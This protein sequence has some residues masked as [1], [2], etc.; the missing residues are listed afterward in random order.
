M[1]V[2]CIYSCTSA[3]G[4]C[5][6]EFLLDLMRTY[7]SLRVVPSINL[8]YWTINPAMI[9]ATTTVNLDATRYSA[10]SII[11][12]PWNQDLFRHSKSLDN[13][14]NIHE[15]DKNSYFVFTSDLAFRRSIVK[16][17]TSSYFIFNRQNSALM[18]SCHFSY[19]K[20]FHKPLKTIMLL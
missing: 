1:H 10:P 8:V 3:F 14:T 11:W 16:A 15:V 7:T 20:N 13:Q 5:I 18:V 4:G 9:V 17:L 19:L 12:P 6:C 2:Y